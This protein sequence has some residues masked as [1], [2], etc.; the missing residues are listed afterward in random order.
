[1][2]LVPYL[3]CLS[4]FCLFAGCVDSPTASGDT[5]QSKKSDDAP[6][7]PDGNGGES[8]ADAEM[9]GR[10]VELTP[11]NTSIE[12]VGVH[13]DKSKDDRHGRFEEFSGTAMVDDT[14]ISVQVDIE[15]DSLTTGIDKLTDHL[16]GSDFFDVKRYPKARFESTEIIDRGDGTVKITGD[17]TMLDQ[18]DS[19]TFPATV[20]AEG[21]LELEAKFEID[22]MKW[23]IDHGPDSIEK[24][25]GLTIKI[26]K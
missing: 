15:T 25:V 2:K 23:G 10:K 20:N 4:L 5:Q 26:G 22:R 17:L 1:M 11:H 13:T 9:M 6:T 14:L 7:N 12:F 16:K 3:C 19:I 21:E 18:T 24:M 8:G